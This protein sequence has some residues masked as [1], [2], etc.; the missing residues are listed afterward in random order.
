MNLRTAKVPLLGAAAL[1]FCVA[2]GAQGVESTGT[3]ITAS[4]EAT[5]NTKP[6][7]ALMSIGVTTQAASSKE[8]G[9]R[10]AQE[11]ERLLAALKNALGNG[12]EFKTS[13]YWINPQ[14]GNP[15]KDGS[16]I[17]G[18]MAQNN[19]EVSINDLSIV[20]N[21]IDAAVNAGSN[22]IGALRFT[23]KDEQA[24]KTQALVEAT[25]QAREKAAAMAQ[26]LGMRI[27]RVVS[28]S[29]SSSPPVMPLM[30]EARMAKGD[31]FASSTPISAGMIEVHAT[32]SVTVEAR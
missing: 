6:D 2:L 3:R 24:A 18:Y 19:V 32:V 29:D 20:S 11:T 15:T 10:N 14:Y 22:N 31:A 5:V 26:A 8:A 17:T 28:V 9:A 7:Q 23:L 25:T 1:L 12:G 30:M 13:G 16:R 27:S 4:A 21:V